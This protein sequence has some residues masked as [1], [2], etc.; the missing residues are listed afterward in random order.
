MACTDE[1]WAP[2][3]CPS[4]GNELPPRGRSVP[5]EYNM[6]QCCENNRYMPGNRRHLWSEHD[7]C[8]HYSDAAGWAAH[9]AACQRCRGDEDAS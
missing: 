3:P 8:R 5:M 9:V 7:D 6:P 4:C 2:V 1:C